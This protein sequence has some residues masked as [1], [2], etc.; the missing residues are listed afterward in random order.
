M[1]G[2][3][4]IKDNKMNNENTLST[5]SAQFL[6]EMKGGHTATQNRTRKNTRRSHTLQVQNTH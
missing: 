5:K 1:V 3:L 4:V 6:N 2:R